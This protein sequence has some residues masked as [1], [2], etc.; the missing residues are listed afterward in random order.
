MAREREQFEPGCD[1]LRW[2]DLV[3][4]V[5]TDVGD[6]IV[7]DAEAGDILFECTS[8]PFGSVAEVKEQLL[9]F[10]CTREP[11]RS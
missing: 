11:S 10:F 6:P 7:T 1:R 3:N 2:V 8:F 9:T 4:L 5:A